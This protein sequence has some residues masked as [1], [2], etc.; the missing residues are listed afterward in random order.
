MVWT[1][2]ILTGR[3]INLEPIAESHREGLRAAAQV[4]PEIFAYIP[5]NIAEEFDAWFENALEAGPA[6]GHHVFVV[7]DKASGTEVGST[8][9]LSISKYEPRLE[10]G[11]TWY[12]P[13]MHG[14]AVNPEA[15]FL[16]MQNA[17]EHI[18]CV[19]VELKADALNTRSRRAMEKMGAKY[20]GTLRRHQVTHG[21]RIR[22][23]VYYSVL[24]HEWPNVKAGLE[25]RL[26]AFDGAAA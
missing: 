1:Q 20:E 18:G 21:G 26:A 22:D 23:S 5:M 19:R 9:Y 6:A 24:D 4:D 13:E 2:K 14:T 17:F 3:F 11:Y 10:I 7:R 16:L 25:A 12:R 8:R 15:K